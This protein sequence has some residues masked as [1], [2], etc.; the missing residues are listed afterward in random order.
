MCSFRGS[1]ANR[2]NGTESV[3]S[4]VGTPR[5]IRTPDLLLRR[6]L[7]YP[8]ELLAHIDA[9]AHSPVFPTKSKPSEAGSVWKRR[10]HEAQ[11]RKKRPR[12]ARAFFEPCEVSS[13][14]GA[15]DGNRTHVSSLEGW[16]ST[17]ELHPQGGS[18]HIQPRDNTISAG[19]MSTFLF[20]FSPPGSS[21]PPGN[22]KDVPKSCKNNTNFMHSIWRNWQMKEPFLIDKEKPC[23][24]NIKAKIHTSV[25]SCVC[26]QKNRRK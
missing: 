24:Y 18:I 9:A 25:R 7:L 15:G 22:G 1:C 3:S 10:S 17:I 11:S 6:Q 20:S 21:S 26:I 19:A 23:R 16:C 5:G 14:A 13:D 4:D 12:Y 2:G 8:A